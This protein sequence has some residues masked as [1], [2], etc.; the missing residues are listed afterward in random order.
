MTTD[1]LL[2]GTYWFHEGKYED[3]LAALNKLIPDYGPVK[4]PKLDK[5]RIAQNIYYDLYNNGMSN[6]RPGDVE[7]LLGPDA[8]DIFFPP[9]ISESEEDIDD[10]HWID[11][12]TREDVLRLEQYMDKLILEAWEEQ[13][14][15][16]K[17]E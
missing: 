2:A 7:S 13:F 1:E 10:P 5:L 15:D 14:G 16:K 8:V 11:D 3:K 9:D 17:N 6:Y 4:D 12:W